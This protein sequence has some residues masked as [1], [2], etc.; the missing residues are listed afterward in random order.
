MNQKLTSSLEDYLEAIYVILKKNNSVKA[1]DVSRT[2]N[3]SRASVTEALKK[4]EQRDLI[5]Y[6]RYD[7]ISMTQKG[8]AEAKKVI[9]KHNHLCAFFK[10]V[11]NAS[12]KE[13]Q[14][15][16]CKIEHVISEDIL[17]RIISFTKLYTKT[18]KDFFKNNYKP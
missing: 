11:L 14:E 17:K 7:V 13:A 18:H 15:N 16:A 9:D 1:I 10:D 2:L 4:L 3:V 8:I 6:G 5:N 12:D